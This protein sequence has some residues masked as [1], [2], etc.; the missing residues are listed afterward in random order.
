MAV[1][2]ERA[3]RLFTIDEYVRMGESGI[4]AHDERVELIDGEIVEMSPMGNRHIA[5]V[6]NLNHLLV[7]AVGDGARVSVQ[8]PVRLPP[9][10]MPEPDLAVVRPR[11]Y[12]D[13]GPTDDDV[14]LMV[15]VADTSLRYD[16]MVKLRVYARAGVPEY[17]IVDATA[18]TLEIYRSPRGD[19]YEERH[20]PRRDDHVAIPGLPNVSFAVSAIFA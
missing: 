14:L 5:F 20:T 2:V 10:S 11:S 18:E 7:H 19:S 12:R 4:I 6:M 15:E 8:L 1:D 9:R 16:R 13:A 17:W 3:R